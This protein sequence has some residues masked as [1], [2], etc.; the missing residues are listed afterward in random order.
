MPTKDRQMYSAVDD[1]TRFNDLAGRL[2]LLECGRAPKLHEYGGV[3]TRARKIIAKRL[4]VTV[5]TLENY[6]QQRL[7]SVPHYLMQRVQ[8]ELVSLLQSE[9]DRLGHEIQIARQTYGSHRDDTLAEAE[10]QLAKARE[11]LLGQVK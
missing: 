10:T 11:I 6:R 2:E 7:K 3:L 9:M 5:S 4:G 8:K 1:I